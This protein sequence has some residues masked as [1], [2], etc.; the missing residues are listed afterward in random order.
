MRRN[1]GFNNERERETTG[2]AE[3]YL[4]SDMANVP[5][6]GWLAELDPRGAPLQ[7]AEPDVNL[8]ISALLPLGLEALHVCN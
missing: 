6:I 1:A 8:R 7:S 2:S 5:L 3:G 4:L